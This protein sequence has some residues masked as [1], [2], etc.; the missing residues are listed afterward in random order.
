M[1]TTLFKTIGI[2]II[3]Y[4]CMYLAWSLLAAYG[5][6]G[7]F[8]ARVILLLVLLFTTLLAARSLHLHSSRDML[9]FSVSW[10]VIIG[11]IDALFAAPTGSWQMFADPNLWIGYCL[12][13]FAPL[14]VPQH[15]S[16]P[17]LPA[18]MS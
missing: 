1:R 7:T 10:V 13:L 3:L 12:V 4:A 5:F 18:T 15:H 9:P 17:E 8:S 11:A 6:A 2:G 16:H 14:V